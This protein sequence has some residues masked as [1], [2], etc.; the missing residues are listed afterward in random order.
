MIRAALCVLLLTLAPVLAQQ[1]VPEPAGFHGEP[2]R[3][4]VPATLTGA[5]RVITTPDAIALHDQGVPFLDVLPRKKRPDNLPEGTIWAAPPHLTIPGATWLYDTGYD[6]IAPAEQDRLAQGLEQATK[7]D[8]AAPVVIFCKSDCWMSWNAGKRAI[9]MGYRGVI[10]YPGGTD[11]WE[12]AGGDLVI[13]D[14]Q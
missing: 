13:A 7:G 4:P 8:K 14:G 9:E 5:A 10:W 6:R 11:G 3:S 2:Y 12:Q 1:S